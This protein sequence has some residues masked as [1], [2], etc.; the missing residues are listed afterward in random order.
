M[1]HAY[2]DPSIRAFIDCLQSP[3][4]RCAKKQL[5]EAIAHSQAPSWVGCNQEGLHGAAKLLMLPVQ[6][7]SPAAKPPAT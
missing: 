2:G 3:S 1:K 7:P 6:L 4:P 5:P